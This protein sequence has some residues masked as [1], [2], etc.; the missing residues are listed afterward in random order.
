[1]SVPEIID[2]FSPRRR[3]WYP[4]ILREAAPRLGY[5]LNRDIG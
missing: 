4:L 2:K 5:D 3:E 1:M